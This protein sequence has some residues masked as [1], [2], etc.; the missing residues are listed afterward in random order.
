VPPHVFGLERR[1]LRYGLFPSGG[2]G[3]GVRF[4]EYHSVD[5]PEDC[6]AEG[7]LGGLLREPAVLRE[8]VSALMA[9]VPAQVQEASLVLPDDWFRLSFS[10][11]DELPRKLAEREEV[12]RWKLKLQV[13]FRVEDLR[14]S[15]VEVPP[16]ASQEE[17]IR[18]LMGFGA[19]QLLEQIEAAFLS[20]KIRIGHI[21]NQ[22][23][24]LLPALRAA[25]GGLDLA[26]VALVADDAYSLLITARGEPLV[27]RFKSYKADLPAEAMRRFLVRD[28]RLTRT[29]LAEKMGNDVLQRIVLVCP[30][31]AEPIWTVW[32][33]ETFGIRP[34]LLAEEWPFLN[35]PA[36]NVSPHEV[37]PLFGAACREVA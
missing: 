4:S 34:A 20:A 27:H 12:L 3:G 2:N 37:A 26:A 19:N 1:R 7:P 11:S 28:L 16:L 17:P 31:E 24:S 18:V 30:A 33:E 35:T 23:L 22:S 32:L 5:L 10:E 9:K 14:L 8:A 29:F 25:L 15:A 21:S 6:F 13:P 36:P